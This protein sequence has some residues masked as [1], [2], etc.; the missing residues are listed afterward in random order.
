MTKNRSIPPIRK[1]MTTAPHTIGFDQTMA[2]AHDVM[3]RHKIRHLP[4]LS[5]ER[6]VGVLSDGDLNLIETL[7]DVDPKKVIVEEAMSDNV[8]AVSPESPVDE[9]VKEMAR[10]KYGS[11]I[12]VDNHKVVGVF[13]SVDACQA[14]A[15]MLHT[16]LT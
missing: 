1:F 2:L 16:H 11:A 15:E 4:V 5:G 13:T 10:H 8:Y 6:L 12:V 3:R 9:V 7:R 14:F